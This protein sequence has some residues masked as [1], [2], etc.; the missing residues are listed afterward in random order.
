M[1]ETNDTYYQPLL[2]QPQPVSVTDLPVVYSTIAEEMQDVL[3]LPYG[4]AAIF[5]ACYS[6][7][8]QCNQLLGESPLQ[9]WMQCAEDQRTLSPYHGQMAYSS[10]ANA[11]RLM[12]AEL[13]WTNSQ[14]S[15][16]S[17]YSRS[18]SRAASFTSNTS[19]WTSCHQSELSRSDASRSSSPK[20]SEMSKWGRRQ[21][22][23]TWRCAYPGC[24]S[25]SI[26]R[27]GCD[28]RKHYRRHKKSLF[29]RHTGCKQATDGGFSSEKDRAR[30][31]AKHDPRV[32]CDWLG[33]SR[34]FSRVDNM[35]CW[36]P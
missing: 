35:V 1:T 28:L 8:T 18:L 26:F 15:Q 9:H 16:P 33:C 12:Q 4:E 13:S 23:G 29:C 3:H 36:H 24:T 21:E 6:P 27:R 14:L 34:V 30:H 20:A 32:A 31:E 2:F 17:G 11:P 19:S 7:A 25:K 22:Q 10:Y 5:N